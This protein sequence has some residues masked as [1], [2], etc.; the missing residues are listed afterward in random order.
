[1]LKLQ[2]ALRCWIG[3]CAPYSKIVAPILPFSVSNFNRKL[4][5][6]LESIPD[7]KIT[8]LVFHDFVK[9]FTITSL[10]PVCRYSIYQQED[11]SLKRRHV[12]V[13]GEE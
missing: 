10:N 5:L 7:A 4:L 2:G 13:L 9:P 6:S 1:M 8:L 11:M 3:H 12:R